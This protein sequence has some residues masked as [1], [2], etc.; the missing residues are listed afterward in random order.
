MNWSSYYIN[1]VSALAK[2]YSIGEA[3]TITDWVF[4]EYA[5]GLKGN[6]KL[7]EDAIPQE[8]LPQLK[9]SLSRLLA[10]EP[11]Q[12]VLG[13]A[14][15]YHSKFMVNSATLI[16]RPETEELVDWVL[17]DLK[18]ERK[19]LKILD[20]G[21]GS[22]CIALSIKKFAPHHYVTAIDI[23]ENAL[24]VARVNAQAMQVEVDF[25][26]LDF[27]DTSNWTL[28]PEFDIIVSNPPYIPSAERKEMDVL[29]TQHEPDQ[30]L[31]VPDQAPLI[32]Y[33]AIAAFAAQKLK[34][35]GKVFVEIHQALGEA[36]TA[37]FTKKA[38]SFTLKKDINGNDRMIC[39]CY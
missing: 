38:N 36:T 1:F 21:T 4:E 5:P 3:T 9:N 13:N 33:E 32:F 6:F 8:I 26:G 23:S 29:V 12:Y 2:R 37:T 19:A 18:K 10:G 25:L 31:F 7:L 17:K 24:A 11:V 15:F 27:L 28:L 34:P 14:W 35:G 30:A 20:M 39:A 16:P 22:G